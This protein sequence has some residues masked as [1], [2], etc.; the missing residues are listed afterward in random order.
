M[1][2]SKYTQ[3]YLLLNDRSQLIV[4]NVTKFSNGREETVKS[5]TWEKCFFIFIFN[6]VN[7]ALKN[8]S[9]PNSKLQ[10]DNPL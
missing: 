7:S 8:Y 4:E 1:Y 9:K 5:R 6:N 10:E 2:I 3:S